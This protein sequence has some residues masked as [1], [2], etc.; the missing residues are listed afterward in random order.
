MKR[1][2]LFSGCNKSRILYV[3]PTFPVSDPKIRGGKRGICP[4]H[5]DPEKI[6]L[7]LSNCEILANVVFSFFIV[8]IYIGGLTGFGGGGVLPPPPPTINILKV[9][10]QHGTC[11]ISMETLAF[12]VIRLAS[13][14]TLV[15]GPVAER[16]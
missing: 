11:K 4:S 14:G 7:T 13:L 3:G 9:D 6:F 5:I 12:F 8:Y 1:V 16:L 15:K 2:D 10:I